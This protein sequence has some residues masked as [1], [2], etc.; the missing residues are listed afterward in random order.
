MVDQ[1]EHP[2]P[3]SYGERNAEDRPEG[4]P[5]NKWGGNGFWDANGAMVLGSMPS[6]DSDWTEPS[7]ETVK[8]ILEKV[9]GTEARQ[10]EAYRGHLAQC[11]I[12]GTGCVHGCEAAR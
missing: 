11:R 2:R 9:N 12:D 4:T 10:R 7:A 6:W 8:L 5:D 3:W 1:V